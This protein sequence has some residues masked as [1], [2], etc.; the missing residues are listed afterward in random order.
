MTLSRWWWVLIPIPIAFFFAI[1]GAYETQQELLRAHGEDRNK[2]RAWIMSEGAGAAQ[3]M[4]PG[5]ARIEVPAFGTRRGFEILC[6]GTS[7]GT[8]ASSDTP[9]SDVTS[10]ISV[11]A[12]EQAMQ[13]L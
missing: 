4:G 9:L 7:S 11:R 6:V 8:R 3:S 13:R 2:A 10:A 12:C 5:M 1:M